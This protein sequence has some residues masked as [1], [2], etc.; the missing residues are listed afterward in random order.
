MT[1][2]SSQPDTPCRKRNARRAI[3]S[4]RR[5]ARRACRDRS[6]LAAVEFALILPLIVL[7][8]F[9]TLEISDA[10]L[11]ERRMVN[12]VN[13]L[14]DLVAQEKK[15]SYSAVDDLFAGVS[16]MLQPTPD[17][18]VT[19]IITAVTVDPGADEEDESDDTIVVE[20]SRDAN[21]DSPYAAGTLFDKIDDTTII[22]INSSLVVAEMTYQ[23][24][25]GL[26]SMVL[27]SPITFTRVASRW[28]RR[29]SRVELCN[30]SFSSC[31]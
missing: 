11:A 1:A 14:A 3:R 7:F 4:A 6:G 27:G 12:A 9:G 19:M 21:G 5:L 24:V 20:W 30:D 17:E 8:F 28:P 29:S 23:H 16:S 22:K 15:I 31:S 26:S 25:S 10:M 13:S 18:N 2:R